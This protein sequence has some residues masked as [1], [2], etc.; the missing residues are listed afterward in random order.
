MTR[1]RH[2][3]DRVK[4]TLEP[5]GVPP[6]MAQRFVFQLCQAIH[7]C[8]SHDVVHRGE[9]MPSFQFSAFSLL[10]A[11][12]CFAALRVL[13]CVCARVNVNCCL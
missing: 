10:L 3:S 1:K 5:A 13:Q 11:A 12:F 9:L 4:N 2:L 7:W 6:D 8:H